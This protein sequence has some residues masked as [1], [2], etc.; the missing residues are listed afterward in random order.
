M[1]QGLLYTISKCTHNGTMSKS[2]FSSG[3]G[4][5]SRKV[6]CVCRYWYDKVRGTGRVVCAVHEH[7]SDTEGS[8]VL[9]LYT[10][11]S[12]LERE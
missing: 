2:I 9:I 7:R 4:R 1:S 11:S 12:I 8:N 5:G 10:A 6:L 3:W